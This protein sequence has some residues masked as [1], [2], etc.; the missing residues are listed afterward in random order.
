[1]NKDY[2][3]G[4]LE[5]CGGF[6]LYMDKKKGLVLPKFKIAA[7]DVHKRKLIKKLSSFL[8]KNYDI[9]L[10][11][12][13]SSFEVTQDCDVRKMI[14]FVEENCVLKKKNINDIKTFI[15][16]KDSYKKPSL[17]KQF[18]TCHSKMS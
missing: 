3:A 4:L 12:Y 9:A 14:K 18:I 6:Y 17:H 13:N 10:H 8:L 7:T 16:F 2:A 11:E 1:M 15:A 5:M